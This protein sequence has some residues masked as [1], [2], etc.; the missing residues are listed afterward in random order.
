MESFDPCADPVVQSLLAE[1][2]A[3][4]DVLGLILCGSLGAGAAHPESDYDVCFVVTDAAFARYT[5]EGREPERGAGAQTVRKKDLWHIAAGGFT[6]ERL[7]EWAIPGYG[8]GR[9]LLDKTGEVMR[10]H[11]A[12]RHK[13]ETGARAEIEGAYDAYLNILYRS[14]KAW[15][16]GNELGA[17][18]QA[19]EQAHLLLA[20]LFILERRWRPYHDRLW[21]HL[22][23]LAVQGWRPGEL[24]ATLLDLIA[25][26]HPPRQQQIARHVISLLDE[27]GYGNIYEAWNGE[28][29]EVLGWTFE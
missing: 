23:S 18:L 21:L 3:D 4:Q 27:R 15:R 14:L 22:E 16:R 29:D 17:R 2:H 12:L 7:P 13:P 6:P 8:E 9:V 24:R 25:T 11:A 19:A 1:A 5:A 28:I 20:L 26:G 10:L